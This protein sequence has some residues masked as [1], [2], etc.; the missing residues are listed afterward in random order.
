[1]VL[2]IEVFNFLFRIK[3]IFLTMKKYNQMSKHLIQKLLKGCLKINFLLFYGFA[4]FANAT[5]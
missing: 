4:V 5:M 3:D 1:M 2:T